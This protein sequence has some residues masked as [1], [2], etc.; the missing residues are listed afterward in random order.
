ME[1]YEKM[2]LIYDIDVKVGHLNSCIKTNTLNILLKGFVYGYCEDNHELN[3]LNLNDLIDLIYSNS[4]LF[5]LYNINFIG[6]INGESRNDYE[7]IDLLNCKGKRILLSQLFYVEGDYLKYNNDLILLKDY[8]LKD[9][10]L[11]IVES[12]II[13]PVVV[14]DLFVE[15]NFISYKIKTLDK[16]ELLNEIGLVSNGKNLMKNR[17][18]IVLDEFLIQ[19]VVYL[20]VKNGL[21]KKDLDLLEV[22]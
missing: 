13:E 8:L 4:D 5:N 21:L 16:I 1:R 9:V 11:S 7:L 18:Y 22:L 2:N 3:L 6:S 15:S 10:D 12:S 19:G 20:K 17:I 14:S